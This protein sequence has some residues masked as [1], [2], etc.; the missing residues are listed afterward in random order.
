VLDETAPTC[1]PDGQ[2]VVYSATEEHRE[3]LYVKRFDGSGDRILYADSS[4]SHPVW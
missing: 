3:R 1:S 2:L 4:A